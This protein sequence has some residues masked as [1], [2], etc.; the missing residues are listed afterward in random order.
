MDSVVHLSGFTRW[1]VRLGTRR[2][3]P[4]LDEQKYYQSLNALGQLALR[5]CWW[6]TTKALYSAEGYVVK[7][8]FRPHELAAHRRV[9][10]IVGPTAG[11]SEHLIVAAVA[12]GAA[13]LE[14]IER[15]LQT[16]RKRRKT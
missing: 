7:L 1:L 12:S 13:N 4:S 16:L 11:D 8:S 5:D 15:A 2:S 6:G 9:A 3:G 10:F 14:L